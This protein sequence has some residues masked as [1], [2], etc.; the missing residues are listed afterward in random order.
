[1][2]E[3]VEASVFGLM[4]HWLYGQDVEDE[5]C[6]DVIGNIYQQPRSATQ[7]ARLWLLAERFTIPSLQNKII[8]ILYDRHILQVVNRVLMLRVH[9]G[10]GDFEAVGRGEAYLVCQSEGFPQSCE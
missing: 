8:R 10:G 6:E 7:L 5:E 1:V 2:L 3:N 4:V 9:D